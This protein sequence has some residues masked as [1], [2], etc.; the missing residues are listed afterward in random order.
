MVSQAVGIDGAYTNH[1]RAG[2]GA[3]VELMR[4]HDVF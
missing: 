2:Q 1:H 3:L 4:Q